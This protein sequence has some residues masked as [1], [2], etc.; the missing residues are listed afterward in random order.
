MDESKRKEGKEKKGGN[1]KGK[2]SIIKKPNMKNMNIFEKLLIEW[3][4]IELGMIGIL[5]IVVVGKFEKILS[6][7]IIE[8]SS[9]I[10]FRKKEIE[11]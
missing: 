10:C 6:K 3:I 5:I 11:I 1:Q 8:R 4:S 2:M 7:I 9:F